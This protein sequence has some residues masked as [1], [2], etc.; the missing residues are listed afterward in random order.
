MFF[1][2]PQA[3]KNLVFVHR[4]ASDNRAFLEFHP[5]FFLVKDKDTKK[6][7]L[8]GR[9]ERGLYSLPALGRQVMS[10]I[11][12]SSTR[13]HN[14]LGHPA[15]PIVSKAISQNKLPCSGEVSLESECDACQQAKSHQL[16]CVM[17][18]SK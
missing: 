17:L 3:T 15:L 18:A 10:A 12:P 6:V 9:C 4:F 5:N 2:V 7:L 8:E 14:I 11:K 13:W 16:Q 1:T